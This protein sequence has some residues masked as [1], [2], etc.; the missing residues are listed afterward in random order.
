[1]SYNKVRMP[2]ASVAVDFVESVGHIY[3]HQTDHRKEDAG[4]DTNGTFQVK[5]IKAFQIF[6]CI[7]GFN[8]YEAVDRRRRFQQERIT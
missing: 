6:P 8:K 5:R 3:S 2:T 1:M 7:T 4:A